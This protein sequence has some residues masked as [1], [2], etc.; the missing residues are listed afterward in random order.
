MGHVDPLF[1]GLEEA[2]AVD[3]IVAVLTPG[4]SITDRTA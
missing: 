1:C 3:I 2:I 4:N